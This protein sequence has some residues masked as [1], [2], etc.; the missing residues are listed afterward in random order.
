MCQNYKTIPKQ[1]YN[2]GERLLVYYARIEGLIVPLPVPYEVE[3]IEDLA[4]LDEGFH[5]FA[6]ISI[7][8]KELGHTFDYVF[9]QEGDL[10]LEPSEV[11]DN[12]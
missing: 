1:F 8:V 10:W 9:L 3:I 7:P 6:E 2:E 12:E 11:D 5:S 4:D